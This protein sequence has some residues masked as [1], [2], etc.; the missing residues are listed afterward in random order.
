LKLLKEMSFQDLS[1]SVL[2]VGDQQKKKRTCDL[3][4]SKSLRLKSYVR[5]RPIP[6]KRL[7]ELDAQCGTKSFTCQILL[8]MGEAIYTGHPEL[9]KCFTSEAGLKLSDINNIL[10]SGR[11]Q[12]R[13]K[14]TKQ[15]WEH[16]YNP[17]GPEET[18]NEDEDFFQTL[19]AKREADSAAKQA[20]R[21]NT[22]ME[23][24]KNI[25]DRQKKIKVQKGNLFP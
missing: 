22:G 13:P 21:K 4:V 23:Y 8:E 5:R 7:T 15:N 12:A 24:I 1:L 18:D 3:F 10:V 25:G 16:D 6:L 20:A 17:A 2:S 9:V 14:G 11:Y 19:K